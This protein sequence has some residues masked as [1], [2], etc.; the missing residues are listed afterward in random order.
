MWIGPSVYESFCGFL[1]R[2]GAT[3][4]SVNPDTVVYT[5]SLVASLE[6]KVLLEKMLGIDHGDKDWTYIVSRWV[7]C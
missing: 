2:C 5:R 4:M 7:R 1:V 3:S 6:P